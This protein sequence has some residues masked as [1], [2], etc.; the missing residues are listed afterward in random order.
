MTMATTDRPVHSTEMGRTEAEQITQAIKDNFDSLGAMLAQARDRKAYKALG[1]RS[2]ESYCKS[3][4]GK[5]ISSAYQ[6]IEDA[7]VLAELEARI[8]EKYGEDV[9]LKF[10]SSHLKPLKEIENIDDKL[11]AIEY[12]NKLAEAENRKATKKDLEI[13]V[14]HVSGKRSEDFREAIQ[15]LGF[16]RGVQVEVSKSLSQDRGFVTKIDKG[17]KVYVEFHYGGNAAIP[18]DAADLRILLED[19]QPAKPLTDDITNKGDRVLI[20]SP[21]L[22]GKEG[23][24]FQWK[25]GKQALVTIDGQN[26]PV[27]IAYA[28]MELLLKPEKKDSN[29]ETDLSWNTA[30]QTYYYFQKEDK[31]YSDKWPAG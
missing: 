21:A 9:T 19:E 31:I 30:Q 2:F 18:Y 3:E 27:N 8:S 17:G 22:K 14:F 25:P 24:I 7:K 15:G 26:S 5:S 20:F 13:A 29:W 10:P 23:T 12:A 11:K 28:E 4:F 16:S 6:L 1:Y